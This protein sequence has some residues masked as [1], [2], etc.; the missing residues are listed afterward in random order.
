ML[1]GSWSSY[2][3]DGYVYS[4]DIQQGFDVFEITSPQV[5]SGKSARYAD[6]FN[7]QS[8]PSF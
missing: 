6:D 1:G 8:Q 5:A 7:P 3:Y 4:N 2:Y